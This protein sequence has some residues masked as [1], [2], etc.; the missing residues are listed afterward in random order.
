MTQRRR[1]TRTHPT[2]TA[3]LL[4]LGITVAIIGLAVLSTFGLG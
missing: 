2:M 4:V 3:V 1:E